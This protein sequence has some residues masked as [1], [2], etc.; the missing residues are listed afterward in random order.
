MFGLPRGRQVTLSHN[1]SW[2]WSFHNNLCQASPSSWW[3]TRETLRTPWRSWMGRGSVAGEWRY[4]NQYPGPVDH[5]FEDLHW[6]TT[7]R[8][9]CFFVDQES[10]SLSLPSRPRS[11]IYLALHALHIRPY[12]ICIYLLLPCPYRILHLS[13]SKSEA[14]SIV[15]VHP[16]L[17]GPQGQIS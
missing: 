9:A 1:W 16:C 6:S 5:Q 13:T 17:K 12:F 15:I 4:N 2:S 11:R 14:A 7:R 8:H 10:L 3:R